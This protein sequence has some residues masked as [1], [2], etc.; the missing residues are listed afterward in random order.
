MH[1]DPAVKEE[2]TAHDQVIDE[3]FVVRK[4]RGYDATPSQMDNLIKSIADNNGGKLTSLAAEL[5]NR[6]EEIKSSIAEI[7]L[8]ASTAKNAEY[9]KITEK[10]RAYVEERTKGNS[11]TTTLQETVEKLQHEIAKLKTAEAPTQPPG[12]HVPKVMSLLEARS[13]QGLQKL[14]DTGVAYMPWKEKLDNIIGQHRPMYIPVLQYI[15]DSKDVEM[16]DKAFMQFIKS[17]PSLDYN[18]ANEDMWTVLL[19]RCEGIAST[20]IKT[21]NVNKLPNKPNN[22]LEAYRLLSKWCT[23]VGGQ[24]QAAR[25]SSDQ[26]TTC[27]R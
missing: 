11:T 5:N 13:I 3:N 23:G 25:R 7:K 21:A 6:I 26:S 22:G 20:K 19:D 9:T 18:I 8:D 12:I 14:G 24:N 16:N 1:N 27:S 15:T 2:T 4:F 17:N 10:L